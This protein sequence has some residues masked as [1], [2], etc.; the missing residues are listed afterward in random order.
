M[1][2][3]TYTESNLILSGTHTHSAPGGYLMEFMYD[4]PC[5][6]F[7]KE[8]FDALVEGITTVRTEDWG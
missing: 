5:L 6:G 4:L 1:Y 7:V 3:S 8:T 2:N